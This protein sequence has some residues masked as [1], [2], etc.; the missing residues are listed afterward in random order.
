ME[1]LLFSVR[2][3]HLA[4][5]NVICAWCEVEVTNDIKIWKWRNVCKWNFQIKINKRVM[6]M[7][8]YYYNMQLN[9]KWALRDFYSVQ[10]YLYKI[11]TINFEKIVRTE[12]MSKYWLN[13]NQA[14]SFFC[15]AAWYDKATGKLNVKDILTFS[16]TRENNARWRYDQMNRWLFATTRAMRILFEILSWAKIFSLNRKQ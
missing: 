3:L 1:A 13:P 7:Q 9:F 5:A 14:A 12:E 10:H 8:A 16:I 6:L 2:R 11:A 15:K 4:L